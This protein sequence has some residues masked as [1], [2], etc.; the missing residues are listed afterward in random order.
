MGTLAQ[1]A[2]VY[3]ISAP[4]QKSGVERE[5]DAEVFGSASGD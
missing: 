4:S 5:P 1:V 3:Y 2:A